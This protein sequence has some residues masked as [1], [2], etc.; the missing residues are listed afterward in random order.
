MNETFL[1]WCLNVVTRDLRVS[2]GG[3]SLLD[4][5]PNGYKVAEHIATKFEANPRMLSTLTNAE[6]VWNMNPGANF[7]TSGVAPLGILF[8][9]FKRQ[10]YQG[11]SKSGIFVGRHFRSPFLDI[12]FSMTIDTWPKYW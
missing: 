10:I 5:K 2:R 6:S 1:S 7:E 11:L 9:F 3:H 8:Y 12:S 4:G